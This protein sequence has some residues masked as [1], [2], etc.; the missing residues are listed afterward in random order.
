[1]NAFFFFH[2]HSPSSPLHLSSWRFLRI[3]FTFSILICLLLH[4]DQSYSLA[5]FLRRPIRLKDDHHFLRFLVSFKCKCSPSTFTFLSKWK[6]S[7]LDQTHT[8]F[9]LSSF[10]RFPFTFTFT[11]FSS[12]LLLPTFKNLD[13]EILNSNQI[14][15]LNQSI[16]IDI[17]SQSNFSLLL[18]CSTENADWILD[19]PADFPD[20]K[21]PNI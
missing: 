8:F 19:C 2:F 12:R 3:Y 13:S 10:F 9:I 18:Q 21:W 17:S 11:F 15:L 7:K 1:M 14:C 4:P 6:S 16:V 20:P 5:T